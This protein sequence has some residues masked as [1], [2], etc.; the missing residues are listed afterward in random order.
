[1][2]RAKKR[3]GGEPADGAPTLAEKR[4]VRHAM[5]VARQAIKAEKTEPFH[6]IHDSYG[7]KPS[8]ATHKSAG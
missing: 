4:A 3:A 5:A 8:R 2:N 1:M 7:F 6:G